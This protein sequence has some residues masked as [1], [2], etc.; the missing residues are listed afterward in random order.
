MTAPPGPSR[1]GVARM[2]DGIAFRY[3][4]INRVL[5]MGMDV[6]WRKAMLRHL[7]NRA[8]LRV[9]DVATG[10]GDVALTFMN[11]ARVGDV[12]GVDV[13]TQMLAKASIKAK[14]HKRGGYTQFSIGDATNLGIAA[15]FDVV[16][17]SFGIRNVLDV[18]AALRSMRAAL[19]PGGTLMVLEFADP[20]DSILSGPMKW[21]RRVVLPRL[22]GLLSGSTTSYRYLDETIGTFPTRAAFLALVHDAGFADGTMH[23]MSFGNVI[24]YIATAQGTAT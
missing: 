8:N 13:S 20:N 2:F 17:I 5:S 3:D 15:E 10:T 24:L 22:G 6:G 16:T 1:Q 4:L 21:Y 19:K 9:L 23:E 18:P 12:L 7:P 14:A 11:D